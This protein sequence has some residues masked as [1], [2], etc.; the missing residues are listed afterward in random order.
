MLYLKSL[1][2]LWSIL[3]GSKVHYN[4]TLIIG[5]SFLY[6]KPATPSNLLQT[7]SDTKDDDEYY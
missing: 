4:F 6:K 5:L 3:I 7:C 1:N 2:H